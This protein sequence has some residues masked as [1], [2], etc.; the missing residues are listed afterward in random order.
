MWHSQALIRDGEDRLR[1]YRH[2]AALHRALNEAHT[3]PRPLRTALAHALR[4]LADRL[5]AGSA[6]S[7]KGLHA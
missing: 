5:D 2:Q 7:A 1:R 4:R 6:A 3:A